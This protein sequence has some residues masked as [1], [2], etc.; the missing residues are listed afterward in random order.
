MSVEIGQWGEDQ[1]VTFLQKKQYEILERNWR[2]SR[3]EVDIIASYQGQLVFVEVKFRKN[4]AFGKPETF[5]DRR[6]QLLLAEVAAVYCERNSYD[7]EIRFDVIS[8]TGKP[9]TKCQILHIEDAFF[10]G[11]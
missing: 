6:K 8:I 9:E 4:H 7:D 10:P 11:F 2:Y 1:A 5:V 3:A